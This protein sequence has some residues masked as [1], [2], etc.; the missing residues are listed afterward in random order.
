MTAAHVLV[1]LGSERGFVAMTPRHIDGVLA[2]LL[3]ARLDARLAAGEPAE[4]SRL[5]AV[6]AMQITSPRARRRLARC[7]DELATR[8]RNP[9]P[10]F[11]PRA[12]IARSQVDAAADEIQQVA[13]ELRSR[14]PVSARGVALAAALLSGGASP[15]YRIGRGGSELAAAVAHAVASM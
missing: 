1:D 4:S 5:L 3:G 9:Q 12:P 15:A 13:E 8:A 6:R 2:R 7:W 10:P 14:R 11:D